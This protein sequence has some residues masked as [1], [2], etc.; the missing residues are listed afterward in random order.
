MEN[1]IRITGKQIISIDIDNNVI[2]IEIT[3]QAYNSA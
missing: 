3:S 1:Y 2:W